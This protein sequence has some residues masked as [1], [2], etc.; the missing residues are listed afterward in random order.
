MPENNFDGSSLPTDPDITKLIPVLRIVEG[1]EKGKAVYVNKTRF[2]IGRKVGD[3][4]L[5]DTKISSAH[6]ALELQ[7]LGLMLIDLDSTNGTYVN[8]KR[9]KMVLLQSGD[10]IKLGSTVLKFNFEDPADSPELLKETGAATVQQTARGD[11]ERVPEEIIDTRVREKTKAA[12]TD[13]LADGQV[14][15][16][17]ST[18]KRY[19]IRVLSGLNEGNVFKLESDKVVLGRISADINFEDKEVA[20][21]HAMIEFS[22]SEITLR[23]LTNEEGVFVNGRRILTCK[24][25]GGEKIELGKIAMEFILDE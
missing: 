18:K 16:V 19:A 22:E 9:I 13:T 17:E 24:L 1:K 3:L 12:R 8:D 6:F 15:P 4:I 7:P 5:N 14:L 25:K 21:K 2:L 23:D 10:S 11:T 20:R